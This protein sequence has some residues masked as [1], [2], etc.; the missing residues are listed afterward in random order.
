LNFGGGGGTNALHL[1]CEQEVTEVTE[2][3]GRA[4]LVN[5]LKC[6]AFHNIAFQIVKDQGLAAGVR[7]FVFGESARNEN[8]CQE[9]MLAA[10]SD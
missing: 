1:M 10:V 6:R 7:A 4:D 8:T 2:K 9:K 5:L 3:N